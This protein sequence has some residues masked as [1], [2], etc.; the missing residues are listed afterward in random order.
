ML[1]SRQIKKDDLTW[2]L[3]ARGKVRRC[4]LSTFQKQVS[5]TAPIALDFQQYFLRKEVSGLSGEG[6]FHQMLRAL[7]V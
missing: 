6:E 3:R 7:K 4:L 2:T 1:V 5:L